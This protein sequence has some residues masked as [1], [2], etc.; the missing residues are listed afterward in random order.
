MGF[1]SNGAEQMKNKIMN[2][3]W[4]Y[5]NTP[6]GINIGINKNTSEQDSIFHY[7]SLLNTFH[8]LTNYFVINISSPNT[9][10]LRKLAN[11]TYIMTLANTINNETNIDASHIWIKL[12]PDMP[13]VLFQKNIDTICKHNFA[14]VILSNTHSVK[15]PE[16]GG[17][18]GHPLLST[19]NKCL[20]CV[21]GTP[22][23]VSYV[24]S[25]WNTKRFR[26]S[27]ENNKRSTCSTN[28]HG[29]DISRPLGSLPLLEELQNELEL[30][31]FKV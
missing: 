11:P 16:R 23:R 28:I 29:L 15:K 18:S 24:G 7:T 20:E 9:A 1:N 2:L 22:R 10:N 26:C 25:W 13:R 14:G 21:G 17:Q 12:D 4:D 6:I 8:N 27:T 19:S 5:K 30:N 3:N 31:G